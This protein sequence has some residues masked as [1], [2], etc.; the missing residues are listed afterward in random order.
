VKQSSKNASVSAPLP[1]TRSSSRWALDSVTVTLLAEH[2]LSTVTS[3]FVD[4]CRNAA[5]IRRIKAVAGGRAL[6]QHHRVLS[7]TDVL[8][9][10]KQGQRPA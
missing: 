1:A 8:N 2:R 3:E 10:T 7:S 9:A 5:D 4:E 6:C